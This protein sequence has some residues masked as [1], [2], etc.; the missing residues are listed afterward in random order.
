M[1][2]QCQPLTATRWL[3]WYT[4]R[5]TGTSVTDEGARQLAEA[6]SECTELHHLD[7]SCTPACQHPRSC[8]STIAMPCLPV[9]LRAA[10]L[11]ALSHSLSLCSLC[12]CL[13]PTHSSLPFSVA[14]SLLLLAFGSYKQQTTPSGPRAWRHCPSTCKRAR[15]CTSFRLVVSQQPPRCS[16]STVSA[17]PKR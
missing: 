15:I 8:L 3:A 6:L 14:A 2:R 7:L 17:S 16:Q 10:G 12:L 11:A 1:G 13:S 4:L 5:C 9:P